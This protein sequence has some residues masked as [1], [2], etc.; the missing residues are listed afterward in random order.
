MTAKEYNDLKEYGRICWTRV[1]QHGNGW[2]D[3]VQDAIVEIYE[4]QYPKTD[5]EDVVHKHI[6]KER[7]RLKRRVKNITGDGL[8]SGRVGNLKHSQ[9]EVEALCDLD[10]P[11]SILI[12]LEEGLL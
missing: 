12:Q 10:T 2:E 7:S 11:E 6:N 8:H 5:W 1:K 3:C 9:E 4:A